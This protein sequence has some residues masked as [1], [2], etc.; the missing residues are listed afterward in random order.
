[1]NPPVKQHMK[2]EEKEK[3]V[4][5]LMDTVRNMVLERIPLMPEEW[6]GL[7]LR[8]YIFDMVREQ[9]LYRPMS[10]TQARRYRNTVLITPGL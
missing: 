3:F 9:V 4:N 8:Q 2:P 1:M 10:V 6:D 7:H 5:D